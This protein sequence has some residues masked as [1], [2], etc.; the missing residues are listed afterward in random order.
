MS[1]ELKRNLVFGLGPGRCGSASLA[2]L[3]NEQEGALVSHELFPILP[4]HTDDNATIQFRWEQLHHQSHL[5]NTTGDVGSYYLPWISFL[6][7]SWAAIPHLRDSFNFRF[8]VLKRPVEELVPSFLLKFE[9]Q[10][11]NPLQDH[12]GAERVINE[13]DACFPKYNDVSL[14]EATRAYCEDYYARAETYQEKYPEQVKI[15]DMNSLNTEDG[16]KSILD[17]AGVK[18]QRVITNVVKNPS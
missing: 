9:R 15:F 14:E 16:V 6:L 4:W 10:N 11:N 7:N 17:F 2:W 18:N 12:S 13:W 3:L 1:L 8:I 5:H